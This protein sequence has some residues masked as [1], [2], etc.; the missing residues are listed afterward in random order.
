MQKIQVSHSTVKQNGDDYDDGE[1]ETA[2]NC[3]LYGIL[4]KPSR[5]DWRFGL[6]HELPS[7]LHHSRIDG[8]TAAVAE[9]GSLCGEKRKRERYYTGLCN[10]LRFWRFFFETQQ[11]ERSSLRLDLLFRLRFSI[12]TSP[13]AYTCV[14]MRSMLSKNN[15]I[16]SQIYLRLKPSFLFPPSDELLGIIRNIC[17]LMTSR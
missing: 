1:V 16:S 12:Y 3:H 17:D 2:N 6:E 15:A 7:V 4:R 10:E 13:F 8:A 5:L 14:R 11:S 9:G